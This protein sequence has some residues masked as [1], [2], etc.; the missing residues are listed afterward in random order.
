M[1]GTALQGVS[2]L[3]LYHP[4]EFLYFLYNLM[5]ILYALFI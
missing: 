1:V 3:S 2:I 4:G 5:S